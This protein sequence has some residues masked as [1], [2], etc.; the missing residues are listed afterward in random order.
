M[1]KKLDIDLAD[2]EISCT[3][4]PRLV[5][6]EMLKKHNASTEI[7]SASSLFRH[8]ELKVNNGSNNRVFM[9]YLEFKTG[10]ATAAKVC[11]HKHIPAKLD[12]RA[13]LE[14]EMHAFPAFKGWTPESGNIFEECLTWNMGNKP[15]TL[16]VSHPLSTYAVEAMQFA[17]QLMAEK[18]IGNRTF[19]DY[20][21]T[22]LTRDVVHL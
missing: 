14:F 16:K 20:S 12:Y 10:D 1:K 13:D 17:H 7:Y 19:I 15:D 9:I 4:I 8:V 22:R 18:K 5:Y 21:P 3:E 11:F 6:G 2:G